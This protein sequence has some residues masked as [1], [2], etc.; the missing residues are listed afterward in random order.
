V[1]VS[2]C[3]RVGVSACRRVGVSASPGLSFFSDACVSSVASDTGRRIVISRDGRRLRIVHRP[4]QDR[5][6]RSSD[7]SKAHR[8]HFWG[9]TWRLRSGVVSRRIGFVIPSSVAGISAQCSPFGPGHTAIQLRPSTRVVGGA[10][11]AW[12]AENVR[13]ERRTVRSE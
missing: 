3:R 11:R 12:L 8:K 7:C 5:A 4:I 6:A 2:A 10:Q 1:G 9:E 13:A